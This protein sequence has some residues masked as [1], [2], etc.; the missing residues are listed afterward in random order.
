MEGVR[1]RL[2]FSYCVVLLFF[3]RLLFVGVWIEEDKRIGF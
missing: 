3:W 2:E 1:C